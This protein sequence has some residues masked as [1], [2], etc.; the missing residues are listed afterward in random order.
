[1]SKA[2]IELPAKMVPVFDHPRGKV[3]YRCAYGGR[4]SGK[5]YSFAL[6][7]AVFGYRD[8]LRVLCTREFQASIR[9]SFHAELRTAIE[10][11]PWLAAHYEVGIEYIRGKNGTEFFFRG[12]RNSMNA[13]KSIAHVDLTIVEEAEDVPEQ[14][15]QALLPTVMR[16]PGSEVWAIWNPRSE[17]SP[18]DK[19]FRKSPPTD[20]AICQV[21]WDDNPF[22]P[23]ALDQL[24]R[25]EQSRLDP[26][27]YAHIWDG[28]YL[29]N[30]NSQVFA[31]RYVIEPFEPGAA[32]NGP[33]QG[34]DFGFAQD[35]TAAVRVWV[36]DQSL[37]IEHEAT[38]TGLELDHMAS[39]IS[40]A[41]PGFAEYTTRWDSARPESISYLRRHGL[42]NTQGVDKW[43]GSVEDG[44]GFLRSFRRIVVHPR[45]KETAREM[46][47]YSYKVDRLTGDIMPT[48]VDAHNHCIDAIRYAV[49]P[50]I[51]RKGTPR[52]RVL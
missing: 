11:H 26:A 5:S 43:P 15:W 24:R 28:A 25:D 29:A 13:I 1:M 39:F 2:T 50:M 37:W 30:S 20:A 21:N 18:V 35:P 51:K 17:N 8:S 36:H 6:M 32:W 49:T 19:R 9:E 34:G 10:A 3:R 4:G 14:S 12:L 40:D 31:G 48:I 47:L 45:C 46:R 22:F 33:Y 23:Q 42:P 16:Q 52:V 38:K 44:V 7:A 41:I 27:T